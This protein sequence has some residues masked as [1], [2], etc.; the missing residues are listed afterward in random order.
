MDFLR[1]STDHFSTKAAPPAASLLQLPLEN[2][3]VGAQRMARYTDGIDFKPAEDGRVST[4]QT[5]KRIWA[6]ALENAAPM[7]SKEILEEDNWRKNYVRYIPRVTS[8]LLPDHEHAIDFAK[9]GLET[10]YKYFE[11]RIGEEKLPLQKAMAQPKPNFFHTVVIAGNQP[12]STTVTVPY[13]GKQLSG[14]ELVTQLTKWQE[15]K[16]MEPDFVSLLSLSA[17]TTSFDLTG[18]T[19]V[20]LGASSAMGPLRFLLNHGATVVAIDIQK[21]AIWQKLISIATDSAGKLVIPTAEAGLD[22]QDT[23]KLSQSAGAN[24]LTQTPEIADWLMGM[25]NEITI[26]HYAYLDSANHVRV[27]VA[28]DAIVERLLPYKTI[29]LGYLMTPTDVYVVPETVIKTSNERLHAAT[30]RKPIKQF[31]RFASGKQWFSPNIW[32]TGKL[33]DSVRVGIVNSLVA[34]QGPNYNLAK[35]IQ[36]WRAVI[37]K[38]AGLIVSCNVAPSASTVSVTKNRIFSA[39]F[40]GAESFGLEVFEP[41]TASALMAAALVIQTQEAAPKQGS[42]NHPELLFTSTSCHG[43][44]WTNPNQM[45]SILVPG[46]FIGFI[47]QWFGRSK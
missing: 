6:Y 19:F 46:V 42:E 10:T 16:L 30:W 33:N 4:T 21:P 47:K 32:S 44:M 2:T 8:A 11:F 14:S 38:E 20:L 24:L 13:K 39:G 7:L 26:G 35:R 36:R 28:M 45:S 23:D 17:K 22:A 15:A 25:G 29:S 41:D 3:Y 18:Q 5:G 27:V 40:A 43:G 37:A 9:R 12:I 31:L 34:Q 1:Q